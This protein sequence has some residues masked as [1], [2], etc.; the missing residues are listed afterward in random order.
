MFA[1][2]TTTFLAFA[3]LVAALP[4]EAQAAVTLIR[5]G[6]ALASFE[7]VSD[8]GCV[9]TVGEI[10][11]VEASPGGEIQSGI[12]ITGSQENT[13]TGAGNG[14]AGFSPGAFSILGLVYGHFSGTVLAPSYSGGDDFTF[15]VDL[16][17]FG[18]GKVTRTKNV[19]NDGT[20]INF[21]FS[22]SRAANTYG[23][24]VANGVDMDVTSATLVREASGTVTH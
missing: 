13:C 11:V 7:Q 1:K 4:A 14:F 3:A 15:E 21:Q 8:D 23:E 12:Y 10:A 22:A 2:S 19:W 20:A 17:W 5:G 9:H 18:T 16:W 24:I 6:G